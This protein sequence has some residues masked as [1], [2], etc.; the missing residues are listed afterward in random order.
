MSHA[1]QAHLE[2]YQKR[3]NAA[4]D[5]YLP[6][7]DPPEHNLAEAIRYSVIRSEERRVGKECRL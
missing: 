6:A 3:V 2:K 5:K 4:L 7:N 1:F